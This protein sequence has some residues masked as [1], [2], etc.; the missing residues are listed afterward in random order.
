ME[1]AMSRSGT[2][3]FTTLDRLFLD[4]LVGEDYEAAVAIAAV[5][6]ARIARARRNHVLAEGY[7]R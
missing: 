5:G 7:E 4:A 3:R 2:G 1:G 6:G